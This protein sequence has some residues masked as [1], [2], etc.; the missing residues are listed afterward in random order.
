MTS[1][2]FDQHK[3]DHLFL[4]VGENPLP[5]YVAANLLL[6]KEGTLYLIHTYGTERQALQLQMILDDELHGCQSAQLISLEN[7]ESDAYRIQ[8]KI[9]EWIGKLD[10]GSIGMNYTGG[11]KAMAVHAYRAALQVS[12]DR[13]IQFSYLDPRRLRMCFDRQEGESQTV[14]I[15]PQDLEVKLATLFNL[16]SWKWVSTPS[17]RPM[18]AHAAEEFA[19][20]HTQERMGNL[21]RQWC[22]DVL[23]PKTQKGSGWHEEKELKKV[24]PLTL[25]LFNECMEIKSALSTL[26]IADDRLS[27]QSLKNLG[28]KKIKHICKWLD[29]EWLEHY[30]L[31]KVQEISETKNIYESATSFDIAVS[32]SKQNKFEFDVAFTRG[33]QLF[34]IS[35]TTI[36]FKSD[37]KQKL[38]EAYIRARQ[39]GGDEARVA[40]VCCASGKDVAALRTEITNVFQANPNVSE[41]KNSKIIV[42]GREDLL[43]LSEKISEWIDDN[44]Q[45]A[46]E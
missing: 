12:G 13:E 29:G 22:D 2:S 42:F 36:S 39:L 24:E 9:Q 41:Q 35:C 18:H 46:A 28:F 20:F 25:E 33:Y 23:R 3:V 43:K 45:E 37:C 40:L 27:L 44:D 38:F 1:S 15:L 21:W 32:D 10:S 8:R 26:E 6:I 4:L 11:T 19:K 31:Q 30:V 7:Y 16:H 14:K 34:A 5:N 17:N